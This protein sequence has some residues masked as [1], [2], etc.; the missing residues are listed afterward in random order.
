MFHLWIE[1]R[2]FRRKPP[3]QEV[4]DFFIANAKLHIE[5]DKF[6]EE[7]TNP[8][9]NK[10]VYRYKFSSII[11]LVKLHVFLHANIH[12]FIF[13][14]ITMNDC[15][16]YFYRLQREI[17]EERGRMNLYS[18]QSKDRSCSRNHQMQERE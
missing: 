14:Y 10:V 7:E 13:A 15:F 2:M 11:C 1:S 12:Q 17:G 6:R 8:D 18:G 5:F 16:N 4:F 3:I 9:E